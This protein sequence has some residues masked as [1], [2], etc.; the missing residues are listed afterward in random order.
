MVD[1]SRVDGRRSSRG[2][3]LCKPR[4]APARRGYRRSMSATRKQLLFRV[5]YV[6]WVV[7]WAVLTGVTAAWNTWVAGF[8]LCCLL[9]SLWTLRV[10]WQERRERRVR[11]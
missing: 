11:P 7:A 2:P 8:F 5:V 10:V 6:V 1:P 3:A 9:G 4:P